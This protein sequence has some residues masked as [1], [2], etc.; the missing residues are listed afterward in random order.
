MNNHKIEFDSLIR[1]TC[2]LSLVLSVLFAVPGFQNRTIGD[3]FSWLTLS[4]GLVGLVGS[5]MGKRSWYSL[6]FILAAYLHMISL[7]SNRTVQFV[8]ILGVLLVAIGGLAG[9]SPCASRPEAN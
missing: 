4:L 6:L 7:Y 2:S 9:K 8:V 5:F 3:I 1:L